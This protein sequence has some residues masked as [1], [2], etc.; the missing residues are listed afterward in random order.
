MQQRKKLA[1]TTK[2]CKFAAKLCAG[3]YLL[4]F[5]ILHPCGLKHKKDLLK[6]I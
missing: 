1:G 5:N 4:T 6:L 3:I 2:K